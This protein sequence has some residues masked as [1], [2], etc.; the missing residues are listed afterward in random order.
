MGQ[1][2]RWQWERGRRS[3]EQDA[4]EMRTVCG[5]SEKSDHEHTRFVNTEKEMSEGI[6]RSSLNL[7]VYRVI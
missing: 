2:D 5:C 6:Y 4:I 3:F 7:N 1:E